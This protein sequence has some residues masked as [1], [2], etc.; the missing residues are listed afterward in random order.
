MVQDD[1]VR[2]ADASRPSR[3]QWRDGMGW[4]GTYSSGFSATDPG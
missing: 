3:K 2:N 4:D 1:D